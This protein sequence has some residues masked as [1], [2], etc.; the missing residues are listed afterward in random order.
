M[1]TNIGNRLLIIGA[2]GHGK[3]IA[4]IAIKMRKW[5]YIGFL[6]DDYQKGNSLGLDIL[7]KVADASHYIREY[8]FIVGIGNNRIRQ[9]IQ[10]YLEDIQ[11]NIATLIHPKAVMGSDVKLG[12]GTVV[13]PG[14]II[15]C[16]T[17]IGTGCIV[18]TGTT[19]DHDNLIGDFVHL[20]PGVNI[21][22]NVKIGNRVWLGLGSMVLNNLNIVDDCIV[23]AGAVVVKDLLE[24]ST[25]IGI[26]AKKMV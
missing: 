26:P 23:G 25:Y 16:C 6:D 3:V 14:A 1:S 9:N 8:E 24:A 21:A 12:K 11:A 18:N 7:G 2:G 13:M 20:S 5:S 19:I 22:G 10:R 4:D 15:N 17:L